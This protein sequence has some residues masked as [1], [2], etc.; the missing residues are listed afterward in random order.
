MG[1][2]DYLLAAPSYKLL[3]QAAV[4][5]LQDALG[6]KLGLGQVVGGAAGRF[7]VSPEGEWRLWQARQDRKT[8]IIFG[9][10]DEPD[11]LEAAQYKAAVLDESGQKKFKQQSWEAVQRRLAI[12]KGRCLF[13]TTPYSLNWLK[14]EVY[15]RAIRNR[16]GAGTAA[17]ADYECVS[18]ESIMNPAFP[19]DEWERA[20]ATL[21]DWKFD[22][23]YRGIFTR[24]A[25]SVYD[26]WDVDTMTDPANFRPPKQW[27]RY[28]GIDFGAPNL[29]AL[30][31]AEEPI[32]GAAK[33][34]HTDESEGKSLPKNRLHVY[35]EYAPSEARSIRQHVQAMKELRRR[36][37]G[38]DPPS[39]SATIGGSQSENQWR[40][41]FNA[42]GWNIHPPDQFDV[43]CGISRVYA[44]IKTKRLRVSKSCPRLLHDLAEYSRPVN[45]SGLVEEGLEDKSAYHA[46]DAAR[47]PIS[48]IDRNGIGFVLKVFTDPN[49]PQYP[50]S[51]S[52]LGFRRY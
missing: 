36:V 32:T 38:D 27:K 28:C 40:L 13:P 8:R 35:A 41:D 18:F 5:Y 47:Y 25:G 11:S 23:F 9:H 46:A 16:T 50:G 20:K 29:V 15:D 48:W 7:T 42:E 44:R 17:D 39:L 10:A 45:E 14:T 43:E 1:A 6:T 4:P 2:G 21:P 33:A 19:L 22:L 24:P 3:D 31:I 30:F 26:C 12:D 37:E 34:E 52:S 49:V 51:L